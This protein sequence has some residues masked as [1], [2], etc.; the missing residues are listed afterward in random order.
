MAPHGLRRSDFGVSSLQQQK[1]LPA[2]V[3]RDAFL[4]SIQQAQHKPVPNDYKKLSVEEMAQARNNPASSPLLPQQEKG[5]RPSCALPYEL[6]L[7]GALSE[8]RKS[9]VLQFAAGNKLF[10]NRAAGAPF[11]AYAPAKSG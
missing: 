5:V 2:P 4:G 3:E 9:F 8:D 11:H 7:D 10:G 1:I 6:T